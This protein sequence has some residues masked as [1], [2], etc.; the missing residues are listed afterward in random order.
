MN[1]TFLTRQDFHESAE[2]HETGDPAQIGLTGL[3][4]M[5][6]SFHHLFSLFC[7]GF[8]GGRNIHMSVFFHIQLGTGF[9]LDLIDCLA[10]GTDDITDFS[11]GIVMAIIFG[12]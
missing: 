3:H 2:L 10:A 11:T 4:L 7:C 5:G 12:A 9:I 1:Q 6:K 8:V